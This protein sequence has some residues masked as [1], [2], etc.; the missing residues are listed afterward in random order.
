MSA[1]GMNASAKRRQSGRHGMANGRQPV[2]LVRRGGEALGARVSRLEAVGDGDNG[3]GDE[4]S[5][6]GKKQSHSSRQQVRGLRC[7]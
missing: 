2:K 7:P 4:G 5:D 3:D 1:L 6:G